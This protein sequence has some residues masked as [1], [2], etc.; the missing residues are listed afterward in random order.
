MCEEMFATNQTK[1]TICKKMVTN[2][3]DCRPGGP[4]PWEGTLSFDHLGLASI[5]IFQV[6]SLESW[7]EIMYFVQDAHSSLS[8]IYFIIV[9][10]LGSYLAVNLCLVVIAAQFSL[11]KLQEKRRLVKFEYQL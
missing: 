1:N 7:T 11:T 6:I 10:L 5:A 3:T 9:V 2:Y 8:W 4:N